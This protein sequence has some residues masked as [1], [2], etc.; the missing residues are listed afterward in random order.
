MTEWPARYV[1]AGDRILCGRKVAGEYAC[2]G[3]IAHVVTE[4]RPPSGPGPNPGMLA[5]G[6]VRSVALLDGDVQRADGMVELSAR[7]RRQVQAGR[8][9]RLRRPADTGASQPIGAYSRSEP[10]RTGPMARLPLSRRCPH[11]GTVAVVT[12]ATLQPG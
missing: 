2:T 12:E 1:H 5:P 8:R 6:D 4:L 9:P 10:L 11:C 7:G 3:L